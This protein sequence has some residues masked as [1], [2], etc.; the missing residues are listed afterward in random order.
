MEMN[1]PFAATVAAVAPVI[2]L[3]GTLEWHQLF[4]RKV[5]RLDHE[6]RL[7]T[8]ALDELRS[9]N[10]SSAESSPGALR[11]AIAEARQP[12]EAVAWAIWALLTGLLVSVTV[13]ALRWLAK[14]GDG[15]D[16]NGELFALY[17][18]LVLAAGF[19]AV[20]FVPALLMIRGLGN[21]QL[22]VAKNL[23]EIDA[24]EAALRERRRAQAQSEG[25]S[26]GS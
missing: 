15:E 7:T 16:G 21:V 24:L 3:A 20:T 10:E 22:K 25:A 5:A 23:S 14:G 11:E 19:V 18:L 4:K 13:G 8:S 2:W 26:G 1:E 17:S 12:F 6:L 9:Q